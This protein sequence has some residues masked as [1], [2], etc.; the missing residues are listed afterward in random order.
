[1][2]A[3]RTIAESLSGS[4][5]VGVGVA[6][7]TA[8]VGNIRSSDRLIW[9]VIGDTPNLA[10]RLQALTRDLGASV[11][12]DV[13]TREASGAAAGDFELRK[14]VKVRGRSQRVDLWALPLAAAMVRS[15]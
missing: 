14:G 12:I 7:G 8:F 5:E 9:T 15:G 2:L 6:S 11:A 3:A 10:A 13:A 4:I 1:M